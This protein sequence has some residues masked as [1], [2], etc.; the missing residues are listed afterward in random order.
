[1]DRLLGPAAS[2]R[3][4]R[5][6]EAEVAKAGWQITMDLFATACNARALRFC[7]RGPEP[8][9]ERVDALSAPDWGSSLCPTCGRQ[10]RET[11][12]AFPPPAL[13]RM[14]IRKAQQDGV[15]MVLLVP[16]A[17]TSPQWHKLIRA[18]IIQGQ[19]PYIRIRSPE[20]MLKDA[21]GFAPRELA[22]F[23]CEFG[24]ITGTTSDGG[25]RVGCVGAYNR[26]QRPRCVGPEDEV[27]RLRLR[28]QLLRQEGTR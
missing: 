28:D 24:P 3:L 13:L 14:T 25:T 10:H 9:A 11:L 17:V 8:E 21:A 22:L 23:L 19:E 18:S 4:W 27:D 6:V 1:M 16:L 26:R 7:S 2:D 20:S 12:Y 5:L 15:R